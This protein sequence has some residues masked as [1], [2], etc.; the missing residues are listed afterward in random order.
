MIFNGFKFGL[1][2]QIAIGPVCLLIFQL[3]AMNGFFVAMTGVLESRKMQTILK[4]LV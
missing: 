3:A 1:L 2:L 4:Y